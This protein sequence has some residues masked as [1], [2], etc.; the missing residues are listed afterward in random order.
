MNTKDRN[1]IRALNPYMSYDYSS[2]YKNTVAY[3]VLASFFF[4]FEPM[5]IFLS[6]YVR[7]S[8]MARGKTGIDDTMGD[9]AGG[10]FE[11][12]QD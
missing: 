1:H 12:S 8:N 5:F 10:N 4:F 3:T 9:M 2:N 6:P 11:K 7:N